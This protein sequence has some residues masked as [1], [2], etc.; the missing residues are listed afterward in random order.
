MILI[1]NSQFR[2]HNWTLFWYHNILLVFY[3][4]SNDTDATNS[5]LQKIRLKEIIN[6]KNTSYLTKEHLANK[7]YTERQ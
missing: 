2:I 1:G 7:C 5:M 4:R 3:L 6:F